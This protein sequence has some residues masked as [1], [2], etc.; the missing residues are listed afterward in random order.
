MDVFDLTH[1]LTG[2][3]T[4]YPGKEQPSFHDIAILEKDGYSEKHLNL[5]SHVGTHIDAPAHMVPGGKTLDEFPVSFFAGSAVI[6]KIPPG[7]RLIGKEFLMGFQRKIEV[8]DFVLFNTG[9]HRR[10]NTPEFCLDYPVM[11]ADSAG[12]I[13]SFPLKGIGVDTISVDPAG[14]VHWPVHIQIL[15][16]G[17]VIIENL[18]FNE[19]IPDEGEFFCFP[20][21]IEMADGS[22]VRAVFR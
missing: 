4:V 1:I 9:W 12:W 11:D 3:M 21:K 16:R 17:M 13:C 7:T 20:L 22:P 5:D 19:G 14:S 8:S 2:S 15:S 18:I 10:W 6:I